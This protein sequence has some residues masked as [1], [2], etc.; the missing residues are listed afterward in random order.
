MIQSSLQSS[1]HLPT[2][3]SSKIC[4]LSIDIT[5]DFVQSELTSIISPPQIPERTTRS[6]CQ[7]HPF[8]IE[9]Q[10]VGTSHFA[11]FLIPRVSRL[12]NGLTDD[13]F[14]NPPNVRLN[15][16]TWQNYLWHTLYT[17][18]QRSSSRTPEEEHCGST[19]PNFEPP[20]I[21]KFSMPE[22]NESG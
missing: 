5:R 8:T 20:W 11:R 1:L 18:L 16:D 13:A 22:G 14:S 3:Q 4:F 17:K 7:M 21:L 15:R 6:S 19:P 2:V 10:R 9:L 12:W